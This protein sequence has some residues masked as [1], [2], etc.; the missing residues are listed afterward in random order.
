MDSTQIMQPVIGG[1]Y[2]SHGQLFE[3]VAT[4]EDD[5]LIEIQHADGNLEEMDLDDWITRCRAGSLAAAEPPEDAGVAADHQ[6]EDDYD[7]VLV[8]STMDDARG[9]RAD[10]LQDLDLFD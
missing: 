1:W 3:V 9:L 2:R 7:P 10:S 6:H 5:E 8:Q 4:D